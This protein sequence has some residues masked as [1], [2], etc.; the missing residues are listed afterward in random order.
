MIVSDP[1][2]VNE[3]YNDRFRAGDLE[4]MLSLNEPEAILRVAPGRELRGHDQIREHLKALLALRGELS[5][6]QRSCVR[7]EGLALL[8]ATW[9]FKGTDG[10]GNPVD[11]GGNSSKLVRRAADGAWRYLIDV[12]VT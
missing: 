10:A 7:Q 8:H 5:A 12:P 3:H 4:G 2:D 1:A 9:R 6:T 11:S